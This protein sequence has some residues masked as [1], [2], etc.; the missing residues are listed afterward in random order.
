MQIKVIYE[1][2]A[3]QAVKHTISQLDSGQLFFVEH[4]IRTLRQKRQEAVFEQW[5]CALQKIL[6]E[7]KS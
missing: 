6:I 2:E 7:N 5:Q 4:Y 1:E 3:V